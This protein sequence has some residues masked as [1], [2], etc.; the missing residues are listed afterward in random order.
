MVKKDLALMAMLGSL[1]TAAAFASPPTPQALVDADQLLQSAQWQSQSKELATHTMML[2]ADGLRIGAGRA[3]LEGKH[4]RLA[5]WATHLSLMPGRQHASLAAP[6]RAIELESPHSSCEQ[7]YA[8]DAVTALTTQ[9]NSEAELWL[10]L[11]L[12][13]AER[14][15]STRGSSIDA[16]LSWV[17]KC[18]DAPTVVDDAIG[19]QALIAVPKGAGGLLRVRNLGGNGRLLL[20]PTAVGSI[21]GRV[22][23]RQS[24]NAASDIGL[25]AFSTNL[26]QLGSTTSNADGTYSLTLDLGCGC[27]IGIAANGDQQCRAWR[28]R[29]SEHFLR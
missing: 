22:T 7:P 13:N 11:P 19:L 10:Q 5:G 18:G 29:P 15:Y 14:G 12:V 27:A 8:F 9:L 16:E 17:A 6:A 26:E 20:S 23:E 1:W 4:D 25:Q 2:L 28:P 3:L 21:S 24:G